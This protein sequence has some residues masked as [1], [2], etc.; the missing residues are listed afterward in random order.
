LKAKVKNIYHYQNYSNKNLF[1]KNVDILIY[2]K[3]Y[4]LKYN[5]IIIIID[6][7]EVNNEITINYKINLISL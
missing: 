7:S 1:L 4:K 5:Q 2:S 3:Y 6:R